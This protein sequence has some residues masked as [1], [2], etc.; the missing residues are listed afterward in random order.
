MGEFQMEVKEYSFAYFNHNI[1][2]LKCR[3]AK[4]LL[5]VVLI[6][7]HC[8]DLFISTPEYHLYQNFIDGYT[9]P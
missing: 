8:I 5:W 9:A 2:V 3:I 7:T 6:R 4:L 1:T